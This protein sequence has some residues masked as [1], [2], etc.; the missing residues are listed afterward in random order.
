MCAQQRLSLGGSAWASAQSDQSSLCAQCVAKNPMFLHADSEDPDQTGR[1]PR[2]IRVFA[3]HTFIVLA[4]SY[5]GSHVP[6]SSKFEEN[7]QNK[8]CQAEGKAKKASIKF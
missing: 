2:L 6:V 8:L 3:E 4:L 1:I 7:G 5:H